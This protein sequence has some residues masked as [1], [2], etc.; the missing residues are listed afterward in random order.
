MP[1]PAPDAHRV[2]EDLA[3]VSDLVDA[4]VEVDG[5]VQVA[6]STWVVYGHT[7]YDGEVVV[8]VYHDEREASEVVHS[9]PHHLPTHS[10]QSDPTPTK[11]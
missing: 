3:A 5:E 7:S 6:A 1:D 10:E 8:G 11:G 9:A 4:G 2:Q